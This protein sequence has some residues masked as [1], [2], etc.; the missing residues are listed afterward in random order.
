MHGVLSNKLANIV[1][2]DEL[3]AKALLDVKIA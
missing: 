3:T 2:T 1:V